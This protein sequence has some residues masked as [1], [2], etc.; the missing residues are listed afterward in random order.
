M[1]VVRQ[2]NGGNIG[3]LRDFAQDINNEL[4]DQSFDLKPADLPNPRRSVAGDTI[5][6]R[7]NDGNIG[8]FRDLS[9]AMITESPKRE[10]GVPTSVPVV[11][12]PSGGKIGNLRDFA[13]DINNELTTLTDQ[14]FDLKP[15]ELPTPRRSVAG[16]QGVPCT[17]PE[18]VDES[19]PSGGKIATLRDLAQDINNELTALAEPSFDLKP[20]ELATPRRSESVDAPES[21]SEISAGL[22]KPRQSVDAP[23]SLSEISTDLPKPRSSVDAPGVQG[24]PCTSDIEL[25]LNTIIKEIESEYKRYY[26]ES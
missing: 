15:A 23:K 8:T 4:T 5:P 25:F 11:R 10:T 6:E 7:P 20:A 1:P 19:P 3:N 26:G 2:P 12:Q 14:S 22:P 18:S 17:I 21:L 24:A 9:P 13:Q 16:V